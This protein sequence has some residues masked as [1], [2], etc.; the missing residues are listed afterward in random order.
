M[1]LT[2]SFWFYTYGAC[3]LPLC[4]DLTS[5]KAEQ[6]NNDKSLFL[7]IREKKT[8]QSTVPQT[9]ATGK[10]RESE[11]TKAETWEL[12]LTCKWQ[13]AG[14]SALTTLTVKHPRGPVIGVPSHRSPPIIL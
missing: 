4:P 7:S 11:F 14:G 5:Y 10:C 12:T 9:G 6:N 8:E 13:G 3:N 2:F 1:Y